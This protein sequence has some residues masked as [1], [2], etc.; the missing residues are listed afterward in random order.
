VVTPASEPVADPGAVPP[1]TL[2]LALRPPAAAAAG[3]TL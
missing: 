2:E 3:R 1:F